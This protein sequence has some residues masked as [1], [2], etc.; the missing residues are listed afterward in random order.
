VRDTSEHADEAPKPVSR[1]RS[2][3]RI[4]NVLAAIT[5]AGQFVRYCAA[6]WGSTSAFGSTERIE[7]EVLEQASR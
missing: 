3:G 7:P 2:G 6:P 1:A 5:D 4:L